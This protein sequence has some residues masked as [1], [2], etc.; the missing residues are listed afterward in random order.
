MR[1]IFLISTIILASCGQDEKSSVSHR[2]DANNMAAHSSGDI[3][4]NVADRVIPF[5][6]EPEFEYPT[7]IELQGSTY[8]VNL[9]DMRTSLTDVANSERESHT[10]KKPDSFAPVG[11][12]YVPAYNCLLQF[13]SCTQPITS[14]SN[15]RRSSP[16]IAMRMAA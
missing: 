9:D 5:G 8:T 6:P 2:G 12:R 13:K 10:A 14:L 4:Y 3:S 16:A 1:N 15:S 7:T 11:V